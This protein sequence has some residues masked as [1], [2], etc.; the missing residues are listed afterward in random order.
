MKD[1]VESSMTVVRQLAIS[2]EGALVLGNGIAGWV[3][4]AGILGQSLVE[5]QPSLG[6]TVETRVWGAT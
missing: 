3:D 6:F 2:L 5:K 1:L 4:P